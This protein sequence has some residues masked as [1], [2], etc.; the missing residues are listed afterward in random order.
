MGVLKDRPTRAGRD[1]RRPRLHHRRGFHRGDAATRARAALSRHA[2]L[3]RTSEHRRYFRASTDTVIHSAH[4]TPLVTMPGHRDVGYV[5]GARTIM[6]AAP[7][8][9]ASIAFLTGGARSAT[10]KHIG[11]RRSVQARDCRRAERGYEWER[12]SVRVARRIHHLAD[13][14][15]SKNATGRRTM[16]SASPQFRC[17]RRSPDFARVATRCSSARSSS[18]HGRQLHHHPRAP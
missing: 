16:A 1:V 9:R 17:R 4:E 11:R 10:P 2:R 6:P 13:G 14:H 8:L 15:T 7:R 12:Q 3:S 18:R 5:D